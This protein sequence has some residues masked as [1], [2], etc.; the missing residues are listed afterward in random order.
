MVTSQNLYRDSKC[1]II[2]NN[3][4]PKSATKITKSSIK[5][6]SFA[7]PKFQTPISS[8]DISQLSLAILAVQNLCIATLSRKSSKE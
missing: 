7:A 2:D 8:Q 1:P 4:L 6:I 3:K 5:K